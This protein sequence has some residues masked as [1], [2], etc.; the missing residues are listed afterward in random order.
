MVLKPTKRLST[1]DVIRPGVLGAE[2]MYNTCQTGDL[3]LW[4]VDASSTHPWAKLIQAC[5]GTVGEGRRRPVIHSILVVRN[6]PKDVLDHYGFSLEEDGHVYALES[7]SL[8]KSGAQLTPL[9]D[10]SWVQHMIHDTGLSG[11]VDPKLLYRKLSSPGPGGRDYVPPPAFWAWLIE[12]E[13]IPYA[14]T[15]R[16]LFNLSLQPGAYRTICTAAKGIVKD[17]VKQKLR[18][19][20]LASA[21]GM[22]A[23]ML[24]YVVLSLNFV[25]TLVWDWMP[26]VVNRG[27]LRAQDNSMVLRSMVL[28][29]SSDSDSDKK[30]EALFCSSNTSLSLMKAGILSDKAAF[31]IYLPIDFLPDGVV[32]KNL[33]DKQLNPGF[34]YDERLQE[35]CL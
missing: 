8:N 23:A 28:R 30:V 27:S 6:P 33:M 4:C 16:N 29:S 12:A 35:V 34:H 2:K 13:N 15:K 10:G 17:Y 21:V 5:G 19:N 32:G 24:M 7:S 3:L 31:H 14:L 9:Q 1:L 11:I 20:V 18:S 26:M 25:W 22:M